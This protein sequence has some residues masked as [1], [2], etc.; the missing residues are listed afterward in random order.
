MIIT[1]RNTK[2]DLKNKIRELEREV[3]T[4]KSKSETNLFLIREF[5]KLLNESHIEIKFEKPESGE[6]K[7][8]NSDGEIRNIGATSPP[9]VMKFDFSKHDLEVKQQY[10]NE[11][12]KQLDAQEKRNGYCF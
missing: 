6:T 3:T 11:M 1:N 7:F 5:T 12:Q 8:E 4:E 10:L 2:K 9:T